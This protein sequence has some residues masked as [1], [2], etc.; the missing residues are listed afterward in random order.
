VAFLKVVAGIAPASPEFKSV[1]IKP[2]LGKLNFVNASYPHP[3]GDIKV[4]LK[5]SGKGL[6]GMVELP[7]GLT[8]KFEFGGKTIVLKEGSQ[9][10]KL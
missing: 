2:A 1:S 10:I 6:E 7:K 5:K 8:G 3:L 4:N 9:E